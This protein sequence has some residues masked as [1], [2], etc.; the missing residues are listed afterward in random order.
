[1]KIRAVTPEDHRAIGQ[2]IM[3]VFRAGET[4]AIDSKISEADAMAYWTSA[5]KETFVAEIDGEVLGTYYIRPNQAGGGSHICNC[6]YMTNAHA[7][8]RGIA[9]AMC[10]HSIEYAKSAGFKGMQ[11]NFVVDKNIGAIRLW[12]KFGFDVVGRLPE[13]FHHPSDGYIDALVMYRSILS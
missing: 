10:E 7:T 3:P 4:Y 6:G 1:M 11:Y 5:E 8:G 12:K 2:I 13:A 9:S